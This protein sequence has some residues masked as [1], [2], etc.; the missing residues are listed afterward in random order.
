MT[1]PSDRPAALLGRPAPDFTLPDPEGEFISLGDLR[2]RKVTLV[3]LRH[4]A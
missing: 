3:F 1:R 2:G 4:F